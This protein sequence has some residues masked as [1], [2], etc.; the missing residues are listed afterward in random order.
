HRAHGPVLTLAKLAPGQH[1]YYLDTV[2]KGAEEYYTRSGEVP[3]EWKGRAAARL[4]LSRE[5][6]EEDLGAVLDGVH[7]LGGRLTRST[8]D[9]V[10]GF[11]CTFCAP[12]SV[13]LLFALGSVAVR[14][15][16]REAHDAAVD[17]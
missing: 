17:A 16:V 7:P 6:T 11:D 3:G 15:Q 2:A 9:R 4:G 12:K 10:P 8:P 14:K 1:E 5:V 13:S